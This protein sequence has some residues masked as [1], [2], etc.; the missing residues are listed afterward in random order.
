[1]RPLGRAPGRVRAEPP[2]ARVLA[3]DASRHASRD[4]APSRMAYR[5]TRLWLS[6]LVRR[7]TT[8]VIP[9]ALVLGA[10]VWW[11]SQP[12]QRTRAV[13]WAGELRAT[14]E[15][16]PEFQIRQMVIAGATPV[17]A[18]E[19]RRRLDL[20]FPV[21]WFAVDTVVLH[22]T[23]ERLDAVK[24]ARVSVE[25]GGALRVEITEREPAVVWRTGRILRL[26]DAEG[27]R[28]GFIDRRDGRADLP[29]LTGEGAHRAVP[30]ALA[31]IAAAR[32]L[33]GR[34]RGLTR[35]GERRW[36]LVL[37][38]GQVI[39]LPEAGAIAALERVLAMDAA[40]EVLARDVPVVD[41]RRPDRPTVRL[42]TGAQAY[43]ALTRAF[44]R[45]LTTQ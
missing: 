41:M 28:I 8:Q 10:L 18:D 12:A 33:A 6:P 35:Q 14:I 29:L 23:I 42:G 26:L 44:E 9:A 45:E 17:L 34:L 11:A 1:M 37:D 19:V 30:E 21:S 15:A 3:R 13:D 32:P 24:T 27:Q 4:P 38:R 43:L 16:Q 20:R 40:M 31:L 39:Q 25:L 2:G 36:D 22:Q 5:L 7:M